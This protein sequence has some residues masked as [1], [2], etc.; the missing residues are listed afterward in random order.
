M[1]ALEA[2]GF[3]EHF[4]WATSISPAVKTSCEPFSRLTAQWRASQLLRIA[5]L[6]SP[7]GLGFVEMTEAGEA[8]AAISCYASRAKIWPDS[9]HVQQLA[10]R[11]D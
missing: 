11:N 5:T 10:T 1:F 9:D 4:S 3:E 7:A 8:Q 2:Q 6:V